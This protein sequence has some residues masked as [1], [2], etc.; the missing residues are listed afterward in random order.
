MTTPSIDEATIR[1]TAYLIWLDEG[2]PEGRDRDHWLRAIDALKTSKPKARKAAGKAKTTAKSTAKP[3]Q[4]AKARS[5]AK[6]K[7]DA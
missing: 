5:K 1:E 4:A 7:A 6:T 3:A 2:R